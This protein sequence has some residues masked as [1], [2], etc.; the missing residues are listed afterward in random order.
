MTATD[1]ASSAAHVHSH[2]VTRRCDNRAL[3]GSANNSE[4]T[5]TAC[6][7]STDP[8]PNAAACNANPTGRDQAAEPPLAVA[9]QLQ[10]QCGVADLLVG[11]LMRLTLVHDVTDRDEQRGAE[12]KDDSDIRLLHQDPSV[13]VDQSVGRRREAHREG[14][15][16]TTGRPA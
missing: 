9:Q 1:A 2:R 16:H 15:V 3:I 8:N 10:E 14:S 6:T 4:V 7:S 11:D 5:S 13:V 12:R